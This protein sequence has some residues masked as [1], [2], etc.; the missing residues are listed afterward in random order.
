MATTDKEIKMRKLDRHEVSGSSYR[1]YSDNFDDALRFGHQH[2]LFDS[3]PVTPQ[4]ARFVTE[5]AHRNQPLVPSFND[6]KTARTTASA[7]GDIHHVY[8]GISLA[9]ADTPDV[10]IGALWVERDPDSTI[11]HRYFVSSNRII[12]D[13]YKNWNDNYHIKSSKDFKKA[14]KIAKQYVIPTS[15]REMCHQNQEALK[16]ASMQINGPASEKLREITRMNG[17][18][19]RME[20]EHMVRCGYTPLTK[21]F[22]EALKLIATEGQELLRISNY[23][24]RKAFVWL[25]TDKALYQVDGEDERIATTVE[26]LPEDIR[27]KIA[28][29]QIGANKSAIMDV[30]VK[31]DD[32]KYWVFL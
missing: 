4:L 10:P 19:V 32:T 22:N 17:D 9:I 14:V 5:F 11:G 26:D 27:N 24:P 20:I 21:E 25:K 29:L 12:N 18:F 16:T 7:G 23:K 30:G 28:V 3:V 2:W 6:T 1:S 15:F 13:R 8:S 31:V